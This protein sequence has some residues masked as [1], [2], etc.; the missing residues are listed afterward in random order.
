M[1]Q[2]EP[3][4]SRLLADRGHGRRDPAL[5]GE[6]EGDRA[7]LR[8]APGV[9]AAA[10]GSDMTIGCAPKTFS[11]ICSQPADDPALAV[12]VVHD[13]HAARLQPRLDVAERLL[14]EQEA[15]QAEARIARVQHQR[16]DERVDDQV[17]LVAS[18][19]RTK[20]RP[21]SRW[22]VTRGSS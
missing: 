7:R 4:A 11:A 22:T 13:E 10:Y 1:T 20:L 19:L 3:S 9:I 16:V 21:S 18:V 17:V 12:V 14:G 5:A 2:N 15:L 6:Q 8:I